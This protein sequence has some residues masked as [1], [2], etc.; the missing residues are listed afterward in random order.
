MVYALDAD[1][2]L[3]CRFL[4]LAEAQA[5]EAGISLRCRHDLAALAEVNRANRDSWPPLIPLLDPALSIL[6][7][8]TGLWI[9]ARND[10]GEIV[11][12]HAARAFFWPRST[13][14]EEARSLRIFYSDP[15]PHIARGEYIDLPDDVRSGKTTGHTVYIGGAWIRPDYRHFGL[16]KILSRTCKAYAV[17]KWEPSVFWGLINS[18]HLDSGVARAWGSLTISR[19]GWICVAGLD[20]PI[21]V[22][23]QTRQQFLADIAKDTHQGVIASARRMVTVLTN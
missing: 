12:C 14:A 20:L 8:E 7:P 15:A 17:E 18:T 13:F 10:H 22:S 21:A 2:S 4:Q 5:G 1:A 19:G 9:E 3:A 11:A 6:T 23:Y 16:T